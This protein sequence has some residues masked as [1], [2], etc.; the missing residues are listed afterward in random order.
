[1]TR[2]QGPKFLNPPPLLWS[3]CHRM[4][5]SQGK[6]VHRRHEHR[7]RRCRNTLWPMT[8]GPKP[9]TRPCMLHDLNRA[10]LAWSSHF[11]HQSNLVGLLPWARMTNL[12]H[13]H[14][15]SHFCGCHGSFGRP[16]R[17]PFRIHACIPSAATSVGHWWLI[18]ASSL[19]MALVKGSCLSQGH[20]PPGSMLGGTG[21]RIHAKAWHF[22]LFETTQLQRSPMRLAE[23]I[24]ATN[25]SSCFPHFLQV[26]EYTPQ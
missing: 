21:E 12:S 16:R 18:I 3:S 4:W 8:L 17:S 1:M 23:A 10:P 11:K 20:S 2:I 25:V 26:L 24:I 6:Y 15:H 22:V 9:Q 14:G 7:R 19:R 13:R 5:V